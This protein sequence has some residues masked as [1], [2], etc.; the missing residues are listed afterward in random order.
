MRERVALKQRFELGE[1]EREMSVGN[2]AHRALAVSSSSIPVN[3]ARSTTFASLV[4]RALLATGVLIAA[5]SHSAQGATL[6]VG[7]TLYP[8]VAEP[9]PTGGLMQGS[10]LV[11]GFVA[12]TFA[13]TLTSTVIS[14]DPS[15]PAVID[16]C[17]NCLTFTYL[18][19]NNDIAGSHPIGRLT[20]DGFT[21]F[22][23]DASFKQT[24]GDRAPTLINRPD[25]DFVGFSFI[26]VVGP[27]ALQPG[28]ESQLLVVQT[29]ATAFA[30]SAAAVIN[31]SGVAAAAFAPVPEPSTLLVLGALA[32]AALLRRRR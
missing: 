4:I 26:D 3:Y 24:G 28:M 11:S 17:L 16:G 14:G 8:L 29:D 10:P 18:L 25:T 6:L 9:D 2:R 19:T 12:P 20:I 7:G 27:G 13:G 31:G 21:G 22:E 23:T 1:K 5:M 32:G 15:N 30:I